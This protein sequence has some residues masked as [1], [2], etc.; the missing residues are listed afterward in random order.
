M[1]I[2]NLVLYG[3]ATGLALRSLLSLMANH[4]Q[5]YRYQLILQTREELVRQRTTKPEDGQTAA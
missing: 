2:W 1:T 4:R 5:H 3:V